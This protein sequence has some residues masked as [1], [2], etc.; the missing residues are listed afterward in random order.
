MYF[1]TIIDVDTCDNK[2]MVYNLVTQRHTKRG[3]N[4]FLPLSYHND[5]C[6]ETEK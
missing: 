5:K 2:G 6:K 3:R 4:I 1:F